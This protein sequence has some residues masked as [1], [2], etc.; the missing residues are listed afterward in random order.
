LSP[1]GV[2]IHTMSVQPR[3]R[4]TYEDYAAL[5]DDGLRRQLIDGELIVTPSPNLRHQDIAGT[6]Y[7]HLRSH[8]DRVGGGRAFIAPLDVLLSPHDVVQPDVIFVA[9]D[10]SDALTEPNIKGPPSLAVEIVS[11]TRLDLVRKRDLYARAA[12]PVYWAVEPSADR[13]NVF[14]LSG[15][16]YGNPQIVGPGDILGID[17]LPGFTLDLEEL[18]RRVDG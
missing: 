4:L 12:I 15:G 17:E 11:D 6:I 1:A 9:D 14:R 5:P 2:T 7:H 8:L 18:F 13:V 16:T 10:R 3:Q